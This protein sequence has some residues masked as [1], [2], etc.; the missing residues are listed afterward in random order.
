M[1]FSHNQD[2]FYQ[3]QAL[4]GPPRPLRQNSIALSKNNKLAATYTPSY[5]PFLGSLIGF[6]KPRPFSTTSQAPKYSEDNF[7]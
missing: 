1:L 3:K 2:Y 7:K 4:I 5:A 6:S